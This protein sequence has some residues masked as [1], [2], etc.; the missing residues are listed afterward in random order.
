[1]SLLQLCCRRKEKH[2]L[3]VN[4]LQSIDVQELK[5]QARLYLQHPVPL[6]VICPSSVHHMSII[7]PSSLHVVKIERHWLCMSRVPGVQKCPFQLIG[8]M[9]RSLVLLVHACNTGTPLGL[10]LSVKI[11]KI[12]QEKTVA[13]DV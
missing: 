1:M 2:A 11:G 13:L 3:W 6:S 8:W 4:E 10:R 9:L 7:C 5:K 12:L